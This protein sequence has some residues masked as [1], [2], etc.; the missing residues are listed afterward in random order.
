MHGKLTQ[1]EIRGIQEEA[2][3]IAESKV[4][5]PWL[6]AAEAGRI[7]NEELDKGVRKLIDQKLKQGEITNALYDDLEA[8]KRKM[9]QQGK[10]LI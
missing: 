5:K 2:R 9:Q 3:K 1:E 10:V 4:D 8:H 6:N 7:Y